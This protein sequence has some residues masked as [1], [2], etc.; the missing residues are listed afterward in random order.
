MFSTIHAETV[1]R[2]RQLIQPTTSDHVA[3]TS[4]GTACPYS[5]WMMT[6]ARAANMTAQPGAA[7]NRRLRARKTRMAAVSSSD[8]LAKWNQRVSD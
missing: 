1:S 6:V 2:L 3:K 4:G 8:P 5:P 7:P